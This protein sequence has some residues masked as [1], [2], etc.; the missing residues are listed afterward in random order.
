[1]LVYWLMAALKYGLFT[2]PDYDV[3]KVTAPVVLNYA[4]NDFSRTSDI[5][6]R[7]N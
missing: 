4:D 6:E 1:M 2:P 3:S 7:R 5:A